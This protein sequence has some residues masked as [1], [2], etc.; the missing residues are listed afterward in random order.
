MYALFIVACLHSS[1]NL[2][3]ECKNR[4]YIFQTKSQC[5]NYLD[6]LKKQALPDHIKV[7]MRCGYYILQINYNND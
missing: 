1:S 2:L 3:I 7:D 5:E 6:N 4:T